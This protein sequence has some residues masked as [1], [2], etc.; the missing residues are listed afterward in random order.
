MLLEDGVHAMR[1]H[2]AALCHVVE[3]GLH[4]PV[5]YWLLVVVPH[6]GKTVRVLWEHVH[7]NG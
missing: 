1:L 5:G 4:V 2:L 7:P 6:V 3:V